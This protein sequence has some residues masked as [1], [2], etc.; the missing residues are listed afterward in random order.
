MVTFLYSVEFGGKFCT[1]ATVKVKLLPTSYTWAFVLIIIK[2]LEEI[3]VKFKS[4]FLGASVEGGGLMHVVF[5][6]HF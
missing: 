1:I 2:K 5:L 4:N 6:G 3:L